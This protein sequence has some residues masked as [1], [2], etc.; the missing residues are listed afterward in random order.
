MIKGN[1]TKGVNGGHLPPNQREDKLGLQGRIIV[2]KQFSTIS[3]ISIHL[4][5]A[6]CSPLSFQGCMENILASQKQ[7]LLQNSRQVCFK[8]NIIKIVC[9]SRAK[10]PLL[11]DL[12]KDWG[13]LSSG[14][15]SSNTNP[16]YEYVQHQPG[17]ISLLLLWN[18]RVR[19][20]DTK[21]KLR[22][23]DVM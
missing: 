13:L 11:A 17:S 15:L 18:L 8:I 20:I 12:F 6:F 9:S 5:I 10:P 19:G 21:M 23:P 2:G 16:L 3:L 14:F 1:I 4:V 7:W 22:L